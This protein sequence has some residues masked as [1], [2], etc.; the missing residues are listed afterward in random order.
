LPGRRGEPGRPRR[1]RLVT[2]DSLRWVLHHRAYTPW[3][4]I[5]YWRFL[6]FRLANPHITVLGMVYLDAGVTIY[7]RRGYGRVIVGR[8]VH[9]GRG[10][11]IRCHEG[12]LRIGD[13]TIFGRRDSVNCYL[14]VE[15]GAAALIAD[16]VYISDFDHQHDRL[17]RPIKDQGI[18]KARVRIGD[19]VWLGV[20]SVVTRG[21]VI[22]PGTVVGANS[23]VTRD[24]PARTVAVGTPAAGRN[25]RVAPWTW[26]AAR[27]RH[28]TG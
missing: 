5:R 12:T 14:D 26:T 18:D 3:H 9:V 24:L 11:A 13:R 7:A 4:L 19:D 6:R 22:G 23:V 1:A 2:L 21:V 20:R 25:T 16:D 17:D 28:A 8:W 27:R 15:I 10:T